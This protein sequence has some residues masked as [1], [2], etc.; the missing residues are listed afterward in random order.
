MKRIL[1]YLLVLLMLCSAL[2]VHAETLTSNEI[3][4][5]SALPGNQLTVGI[6]TPFD[7]KF[8]T[9]MWGNVTSDL[10]IRMLIHGYNL[11]EWRSEE[12]AFAVDPSVVSGF[13]VTENQR[14][15]RTYTLS[16]YND[17]YYSDGTPITAWDYA[18]SI[19]LGMAPQ[20]AEIGGSPRPM[21]YLVGYQAYA[22]GAARQ[23]AGVRVLADHVL[24]ITISYEYLP[25]FYEQGL[26][27]CTPCPIA[28]IA[29]GCQVRDD[30][31]GVYIDGQGGAAFTAEL[32]RGTLLDP[33]NGYMAHPGVTSGPYRLVAFDGKQA[34]LEINPYY[35]G[36][37]SGHKPSIQRLVYRTVAED[38]MMSLLASG[39]VNLLTKCTSAD[40][41]REG[42]V[43]MT[44]N[45]QY[46]VANYARSGMGYIAF[47]CE[48]DTVSSVAVRQAVAYCLDKDAL[49][50]DTVDAFGMRTDGYYG[51]G[52][53]MYQMISGEMQL[54]GS[55]AGALSALSMDRVKRY[56]LNPQEAVRLLEADGWTLNR[57]GGAFDPARDDV[58]CKQLNG[59]L[60]PLKLTLVCPEEN[61]KAEA[62]RSAL[63]K[64]MAQ[65]GMQLMVQEEPMEQVLRQ[66]YREQERSCDM[67]FM[68]SNFDV[69]FDPSYTFEPEG[70]YNASAISDARLYQLAENMNRTQPDDLLGYMVKWLAFQQRFQEVVPMI[71]VYSNTY[72]DFYP[73]ALQ[74]YHIAS[75]ISWSQA[76][77]DASLSDA[78]DGAN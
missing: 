60:V 23:L 19:L 76:I 56:E 6:T 12:A 25:F 24:A 65:A 73:R 7:G 36:N 57:S 61:G 53:W 26:L 45:P 64:N 35:K 72:F 15:D 59:M 40:V 20:I 77:A 28:V 8:F 70:A 4:T 78:P 17:L 22:S 50:K 5:G 31:N 14:G 58:R 39:E 10:D 27:D 55:Q 47:C 29:P 54:T 38:E 33:E 74:E 49:V 1:V 9:R 11:V 21:D 66:Y 44:E 16:L 51:M 67:I 3:S 18:F 46:T 71:P 69:V 75:A 63:G 52:Q 32:L 2:P 41:V 13:L 68:A 30:G 43:L 62:I 37:S 34:D 48:Q 42:L